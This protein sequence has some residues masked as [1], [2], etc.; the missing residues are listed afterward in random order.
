MLV[1]ENINIHVKQGEI[2]GIY[3]PNGAGKTTLLRTIAGLLRPLGGKIYFTGIDITDMSARKRVRLGIRYIP[4]RGHVFRSLSVEDNIRLVHTGEIDWDKFL[5]KI[6]RR[7]PAANLSGGQMRLLSLAMA[8]YTRPRLLLLDEPSQGL[9]QRAKYDVILILKTLKEEGVT[10][11][12]AEQDAEFISSLADRI[13][14]IESGIIKKE[15]L[16]NNL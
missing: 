6:N 1:A 7:M 5:L 4:D 15:V 14:I 16:P 13:Y 2:V 3:G 12:I 11:L 9:F 8:Y 10:M